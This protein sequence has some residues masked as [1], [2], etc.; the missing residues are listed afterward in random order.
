MN[1]SRHN[2]WIIVLVWVIAL[3]VAAMLDAP[4]AAFIRGSGIESFV[5]SHRELRRTLKV[6]GEYWFTIIVMLALLLHRMNWR[7]S[8]LMLMGTAVSGVNGL[9]KWVVGRIRPYKLFDDQDVARLAPFDVHPF[10][11]GL[12]GLFGGVKNLCFP[13]GHAALAFATAAASAILLPRWRW[14]FYGVATLVAL[15]RLSENAHWLSDNV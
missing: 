8:L 10:I 13:S 1:R 4:V 9:T 6:P 14:L 7:A 5:S 2:T 11:G 3:A 12:H 15:E